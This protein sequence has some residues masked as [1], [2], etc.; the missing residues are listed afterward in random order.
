MCNTNRYVWV[1]KVLVYCRKVNILFV[2]LF[3]YGYNDYVSFAKVNQSE[4]Y[5][6]MSMQYLPPGKMRVLPLSEINRRLVTLS[7][8]DMHIW[9]KSIL[10]IGVASPQPDSMQLSKD[11]ITRIHRIKQNL[12]VR[13]I[14]L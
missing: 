3:I 13:R 1:N 9:G 14:Y 5:S 2:S 7:K 6:Y 11:E 4:Y 12:F 8:I 10:S